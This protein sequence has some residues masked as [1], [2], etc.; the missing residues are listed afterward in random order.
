MKKRCILGESSGVRYINGILSWQGVQLNVHCFE[1]DG[2][3]IDTGAQ[4]LLEGFKPFFAAADVE[5]IFI[6]HAHEDHTGGARFL[7]NEYELPI[8]IHEMSI[9]ECAEKAKYPLYRKWYW[10]KRRPFSAQLIGESFTSRNCSWRAIPTPGHSNDHLVFLNNDTG[11]L[12]S[13]D[14]FVHPK[15]KLIMREESI[16][17]IISSIEVVL[18]LEFDELFCCHAGYV[19]EGR[20]AFQSKLEYLYELRA[21]TLELYTKGCPAKEIQAR[22]FPKKYPI[23][24]FSSGEWDSI[25]MIHSIIKE[26]GNP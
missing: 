25:H 23:S 3:L 1:T 6:T 9:D 20:K 12:F 11:Q 26:A 10:G 13:G 22:L 2:V 16:P 19:K 18:A 24:R 15:T 5:Q 7:Q 8:Y 21:Q 14:L 17:D 4:S